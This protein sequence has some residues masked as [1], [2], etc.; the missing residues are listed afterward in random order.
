[1]DLSDGCFSS[2][3]DVQNC[4]ISIHNITLNN[5]IINFIITLLYE[6][7]TLY[8]TIYDGLKNDNI[9]LLERSMVTNLDCIFFNPSEKKHYFIQ[10][11]D[12]KFKT[13][14]SITLVIEKDCDI[15]ILSWE[16][17]TFCEE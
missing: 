3:Q 14:S 13:Q 1:M 10:S 17:K 4:G 5:N 11:I 8:I 7:V 6:N 15:D 9:K 16:V 2:F 12:V